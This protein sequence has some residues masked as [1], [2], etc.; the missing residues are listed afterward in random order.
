[1]HEEGMRWKK[2]MYKDL[3]FV[4]AHLRRLENL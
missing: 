1:M 3:D 2:V 4:M